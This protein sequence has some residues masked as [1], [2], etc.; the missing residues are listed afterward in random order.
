ML[1]YSI[2]ER[3]PLESHFRKETNMAVISCLVY[4]YK[5]QRE[6]S[7]FGVAGHIYIYI[8][9]EFAW[10]TEDLLQCKILSALLLWN[11]LTVS[12]KLWI[13]DSEQNNPHL[14][15]EMKVVHKLRDIQVQAAKRIFW[16]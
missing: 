13:K 9:T 7:H 5:F 16:R 6:A 14:K 8:Y 15:T 11:N 4:G 1:D 12:E 2:W 10:M 3:L